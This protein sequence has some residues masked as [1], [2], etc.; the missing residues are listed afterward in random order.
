MSDIC[1]IKLQVQDESELY[2]PLDGEGRIFSDEVVDFIYY[3]S[4]LNL[5]N[6]EHLDC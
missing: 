5:G 4:I 1:E 6:R 3:R 2:N